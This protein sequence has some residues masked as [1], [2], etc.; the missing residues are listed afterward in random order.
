M[1]HSVCLLRIRA[2]TLCAAIVDTAPCSEC[3]PCPA[4]SGAV[5]TRNCSHVSCAAASA[6]IQSAEADDI[7]EIGRTIERLVVL[8]VMGRVEEAENNDTTRR[9]RDQVTFR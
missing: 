4:S 5:A 3:W 7:N 6:N 8:T 2:W 1:R 9:L